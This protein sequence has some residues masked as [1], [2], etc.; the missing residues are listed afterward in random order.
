MT[1]RFRA[2]RRA[3][4]LRIVWVGFWLLL[5]LATHKPMHGAPKWAFSGMDKLAHVT[6]YCVLT[7]LGGRYLEA[8]GR[9]LTPALLLVWVGVYAAFAVVDEWSQQFVGRD[10]S[11]A[12]WI[13]DLVGIVAGTVVLAQIGR[14]H[15]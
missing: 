12:D 7:V 14:A 15:V 11:L 10:T 2:P 6:L 3:T 8:T 13:A 1:F 9:S 4:M 5:F